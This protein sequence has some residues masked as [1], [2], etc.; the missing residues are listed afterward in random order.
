MGLNDWSYS[1]K[2][3]IIALLLYPLSTLIAWMIFL[4]MGDFCS[5]IICISAHWLPSLLVWPLISNLEIAICNGGYNE[6]WQIFWTIR[7]I[8]SLIF[9]AVIG[10]F[11]GCIYGKIKSK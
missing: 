11:I 5:G 9:Y 8:A 1:F 3:A 2:G 4:I 6:C 7:I 10:S